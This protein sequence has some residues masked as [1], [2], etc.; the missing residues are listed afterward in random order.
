MPR[1]YK[2]K[3]NR[4][5]IDEETFKKAIA[6]VLKK[7]ETPTTA[8][9]K[10]GIKRTTLNSRL[11]KATYN[12]G[13]ADD[14]GNSGSE[15]EMPVQHYQSKFTSK[16]VFT[17]SEEIELSTYIKK[18][19]KLQYG[20]T[21][22]AARKLAFDFAKS[23]EIIHPDNWNTNNMAG[24]DWIQGFLRRNNTLSLRKPEN[25]SLARS[26]G[27][28]R[29]AVEEFFNNLSEM[30]L[31]YNFEPKQIYNLDESGVNTVMETPKVNFFNKIEPKNT[32]T[33]PYK[34]F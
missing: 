1:F 22:K 34:C 29:I 3:T 16:Q 18:C 26:T 10:Y 25:T 12:N 21:F 28:N 23:N 6:D 2:K 19:S 11:K 13:T 20:L 14:S 31:K 4:P 17:E 27:F 30:L 33:L 8:A 9:L 15:F 32:N 5:I 7:N 24:L